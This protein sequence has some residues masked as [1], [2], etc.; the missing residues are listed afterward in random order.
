MG[1]A[2]AALGATA[3]ASAVRGAGDRGGLPQPTG[4]AV[5]LFSC[6]GEREGRRAR[7]SAGAEP[8]LTCPQPTDACARSPPPA[9]PTPPPPPQPSSLHPHTLLHVSPCRRRSA[10]RACVARAGGRLVFDA[11]ES[12]PSAREA[13]PAGRPSCLCVCRVLCVCVCVCGACVCACVGH[14]RSDA[15]RFCASKSERARERRMEKK[16]ALSLSS[17]SSD[18]LCAPP[19]AHAL[20]GAT[21]STTTSLLV[22]CVAASPLFLGEGHTN[23]QNDTRRGPLSFPACDSPRTHRLPHSS[24]WRLRLACGR[25]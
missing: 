21:S 4:R 12:K 24:A 10:C 15:L 18:G 20:P 23:T 7:V 5:T 8:L 1:D 22:V 2:L 11:R 17:L 6:V 19:P 25:R 16:H 3:G 14:G 9:R 13:L